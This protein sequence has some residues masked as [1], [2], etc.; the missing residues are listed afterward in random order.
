MKVYTPLVLLCTILMLQGCLCAVIVGTAAIV[1]KTSTDP[2]TFGRQVDDSTLEIRITNA[3]ANDQQLK[4]KTRIINTVY[5]S[6]VLLTGQ[7]L[8]A[9][10]AKRANQ[11]ALD[12]DGVTQV[13]NEI[14]QGRPVLLKRIC[15]DI[16]ITTKIRS[17][18]LT[19]NKVNFSNIKVTTE[20]G[21]VFLLGILTN[22]EGKAAGEIASRI[23]GVKRVTIAFTYLQ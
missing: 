12:V 15:I 13:Y 14:R 5:Q 17:L 21:E 10:L 1:T 19:S 3:L 9:D 20:N 23:N 18:F 22:A 8:T 7:V 6:K 11:I 16:W 2:R 4:K